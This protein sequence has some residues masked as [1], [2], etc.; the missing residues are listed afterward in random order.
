M[1]LVATEI[2]NGGRIV[3]LAEIRQ[4]VYGERNWK[5]TPGLQSPDVTM[6]RAGFDGNFSTEFI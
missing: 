5:V 6:R 3:R 4:L 1:A 2:D